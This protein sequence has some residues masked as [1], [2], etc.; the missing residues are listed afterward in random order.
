MRMGKVYSEK[1]A[2]SNKFHAS[3]VPLCD[4]CNLTI[5]RYDPWTVYNDG[6]LQ[7]W[8]LILRYCSRYGWET[9]LQ[10][11][12]QRCIKHVTHTLFSVSLWFVWVEANFINASIKSG[13][14]IILCSLDL[15]DLYTTSLF[16]SVGEVPSVTIL[17]PVEVAVSEFGFNSSCR[18]VSTINT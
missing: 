15:K 2:T 16:Q 9:W 18:Y 11:D 13:S 17:N 1:I 10:K 14:Y 6:I 3:F 4:V 5:A 7:I 12:L 8:I